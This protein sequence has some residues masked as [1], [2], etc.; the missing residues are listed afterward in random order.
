MPFPRARV[1]LINVERS[2]QPV[3]YRPVCHPFRI[4]PDYLGLM[5]SEGCGMRAQFMLRRIRV[6]F[7]K[8]FA[9]VTVADFVFIKRIRW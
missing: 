2:V 1:D 9:T 7:K 6:R 5:G 3:P 4:L 8:D